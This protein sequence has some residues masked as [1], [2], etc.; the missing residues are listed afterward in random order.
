MHSHTMTSEDRKCC[1][2]V[3]EQI[4]FEILAF[5]VGKHMCWQAVDIQINYVA[6]LQRLHSK[7]KSTSEHLFWCFR[8]S[9]IHLVFIAEKKN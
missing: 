1:R 6:T 7:K 8:M 4:D 5:W 3:R 2:V 9:Q